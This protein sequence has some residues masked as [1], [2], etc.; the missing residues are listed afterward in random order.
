MSHCQ[1]LT[2]G[3][4]RNANSTA[5]SNHVYKAGNFKFFCSFLIFILQREIERKTGSVKTSCKVPYFLFILSELPSKN[6][7]RRLYPRGCFQSHILFAGRK[8]CHSLTSHQCPQVQVNSKWTRNLN[9]RYKTCP[10]KF[11]KY[12]HGKDS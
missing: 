6:T 3:A 1:T 9:G 11:P 12:L 4:I 8:H 10:Q 7:Y 2:L 5:V